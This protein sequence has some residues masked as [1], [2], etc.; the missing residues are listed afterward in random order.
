MILMN[1]G[2]N[3]ESLEKLEKILQLKQ[4]NFGTSSSEVRHL[5]Y[6]YQDHIQKH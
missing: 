6:I 2:S 1:Q 4:V 5:P 3:E